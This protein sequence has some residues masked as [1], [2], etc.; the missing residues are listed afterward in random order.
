M[1]KPGS[2]SAR[3]GFIQV[4]TQLFAFAVWAYQEDINLRDAGDMAFRWEQVGSCAGLVVWVGA[5]CLSNAA[6]F[7]VH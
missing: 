5:M 7:S 6:L 2:A 4:R 1:H 3:T